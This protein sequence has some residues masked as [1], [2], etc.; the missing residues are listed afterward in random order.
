[1][2]AL[3]GLIFDLDGTMLDSAPDVRQALNS[4]LETHGRR[5]LTLDEVESMSGDGLLPQLQRAL[6][7]TGA[8]EPHPMNYFQEFIAAYRSLKPDPAQIYP[9]VRA[10][11]EYYFQHGVKLGV[12]TNK[13]EAATYRLLEQLDLK[14]Y[15]EF[16]AGGDTF[17]THKPN[18]D[19]VY[20][21]IC[22]LDVP[23][24][25]CVM[26]G[27]SPN[28]VIA[29]H[30]AGIPCIAVAHGYALDAKELGA[31]A[32]IEGYA[33]LEGALAGLGFAVG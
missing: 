28:D 32:V 5:A 24:E 26:I 30:G 15:F 3:Q 10:T 4:M 33:E 8:E 20:G 6:A 29:S 1:M 27:D 16:I 12:C 21:V 11:L 13:Q 17:S 31:D 19:H 23:R 18:P 22:A 14:K 7:A 2:P 25:N 9:D